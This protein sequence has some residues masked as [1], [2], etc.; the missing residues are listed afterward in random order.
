MIETWRADT[1][2]NV[3]VTVYSIVAAVTSTYIAVH[4]VYTSAMY[5][6]CADTVVDVY[7]TVWACV[8]RQTVTAINV[9]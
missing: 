5:T 8:S 6:W 4:S 7:G 9:H 2:V 3:S 1:L